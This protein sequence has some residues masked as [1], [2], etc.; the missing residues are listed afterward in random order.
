VFTFGPGPL[1]AVD[2]ETFCKNE[3]V[4]VVGYPGR[5]TPHKVSSVPSNASREYSW[6]SFNCENF[7]RHAHALKPESPQVNTLVA[8]AAVAL[9]A[10]AAR[11]MS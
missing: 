8:F 2:P 3:V 5:L 4:R 11:W 9:F 7:V 1:Q 6:L 10:V